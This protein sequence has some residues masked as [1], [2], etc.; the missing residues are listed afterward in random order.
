MPVIWHKPVN[1]S[2]QVAQT[3]YDYARNRMLIRF[4]RGEAIYAYPAATREDEASILAGLDGS[5]GRA[6][7]AF[8]R[9]DRHAGYYTIEHEDDESPAPAAEGTEETNP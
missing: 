9:T 7:N 6:L 8:K 5:A 2:S 4:T 3:A 1:P